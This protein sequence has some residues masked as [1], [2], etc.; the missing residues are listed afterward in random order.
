MDNPEQGRSP[1]PKRPKVTMDKSMP[2]PSGGKNQQTIDSYGKGGSN[3]GKYNRTNPRDG[4][5]LNSQPIEV[6]I[7]KILCNSG[8][9]N[10]SGIYLGNF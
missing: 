8:S 1:S 2:S 7:S 5:V 3:R 10:F 9:S 4:P 6:T